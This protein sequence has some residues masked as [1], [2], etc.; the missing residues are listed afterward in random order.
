MRFL[1]R[2]RQ[3]RRI[4]AFEI[5]E[6][7]GEGGMCTV[8]RAR[9]AS[10]DRPVAVKVLKGRL[11]NDPE[12]RDRFERES[13]IV[14]RL[15]HPNIIHVIDRGFT[16][17]GAPYFVMEYLDGIDLGRA[18][19]QG[20]LDRAHKLDIAVQ[21]CRALAYAHKNGV[22]HRDIKP[23]NIL[24]DREGNA[25]VLDFGIAKLMDP[26]PATETRAD[27]VLGTLA[28]M[29]PEQQTGEHPITGASDIYSLGVV[30]YEMVTGS[31]PLGIYRRPSQ[32]DP[33]I[34]LELDAVLRRCLEPQPVARFASAEE[35]RDRL[36][37]IL[38]GA[39]LGTEQ[40]DRAA[41]GLDRVREKFAL[42]DV[43]RDAPTGAV[44]LYQDRV[45]R[46][47]LVIRKRLGSCAG[48]AEAKL[49]AALDHQ[50]IVKV[51][52]AS[53]D[54]RCFIVVMEYLTGG[55]LRDR[56]LQPLPVAEALRVGREAAEGLAFAHRNR[57]AHGTLRPENLLFTG[58]GSVRVTD[59]G[60]DEHLPA[61]GNPYNP[62]GE[63][64]SAAADI[65]A[66]GIILHRITTGVMPAWIDGVLSLYPQFL[67]LPPEVRE[68]LAGMLLRNPA[69][70]V[71]SCDQVVARLH[72]AETSL[73]G[74]GRGEGR[75]LRERS[76]GS[77]RAGPDVHDEDLTQILGPESAPAT[78]FLRRLTEGLRRLG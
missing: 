51:H 41:S 9:Q 35:L 2:H 19:A 70:R 25:I 34:P 17:D 39:H 63:P 73:A 32:I 45:D 28:Y 78:G 30:L 54:Q 7:I 77:V 42:L 20:G 55:S 68:I 4:G 69:G 49:L 26:G 14:A 1:E 67:R 44:Y 22:V 11:G 24:V 16:T 59:F 76:G 72:A 56:L 74:T 8:Y 15:N 27:L 12:V 6:T 71:G 18:L 36:L 60:L 65:L 61:T 10:L 53:G 37:E 21:V 58:D 38:Q 40:R 31:K 47:L 75:V 50:R 23:A 33:T 5:V 48:L 66:L 13:L 62:F 3:P 29:S 57:I 43:I 64:R 46:R 52:G